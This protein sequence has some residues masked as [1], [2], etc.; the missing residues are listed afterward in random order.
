M[1]PGMQGSVPGVQVIRRVYPRGGHEWP[2]FL[3]VVILMLDSVLPGA[4]MTEQQLLV[5][6]INGTNPTKTFFE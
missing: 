4:E 2:P 6:V 1:S 5:P 3:L